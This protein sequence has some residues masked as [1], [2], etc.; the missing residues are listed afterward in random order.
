MIWMK[1]KANLIVILGGL[2]T[3]SVLALKILFGQYQRAKKVAKEMK[4]RNVHAKKVR[5]KEQEHENEFVSRS[6]KLAKDIEDR[7]S[8]KE[9]EKP[10]IKW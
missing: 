2:L 3:L 10:N 5:E 4:A 8:S 9:L 7:K 6:A 1:I